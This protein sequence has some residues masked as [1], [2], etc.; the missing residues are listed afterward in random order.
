MPITLSL[1]ESFF[2]SHPHKALLWLRQQSRLD[3][4]EFNASW[5]QLGDP[6]H[7]QDVMLIEQTATKMEKNVL[8]GTILDTCYAY[9]QR[10]TVNSMS[11]T[12]TKWK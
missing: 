10:K 6:P 2:S 11:Q 9:K 4:Q 1:A 3:F 5:C 8:A 12:K 7:P